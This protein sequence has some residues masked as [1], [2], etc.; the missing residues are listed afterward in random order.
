MNSEELLSRAEA[1]IRQ[2]RT[3]EVQLQFVDRQ[4]HPL[5]NVRGRVRLARHEFRLGANAFRV[6]NI[7]DP[8]LQEAYNERFAALLNYATLPFYWAGYEPQPG[9]TSE[10]RLEAM[11]AWCQAH[12]ITPKGHP[13][14][15]HEVYPQW[16]QALDDAEVLDRLQRRVRE[17]VAHFMGEIDLWDVVNEATVSHRFDNAIGR[18]IARE[19]AAKA[20]AQA[21]AWA[22]AGNP[23]AT[24]LYNDFNLSPDFERLIA[25][26]LGEGAPL[27]AIGVQSH[28]HRELWPLEKAWR[29]CETY[30]RF[31]LP[32]H[33]TEV[34]VLSGRLKAA[35]D[36]DW[37]R[38]H[39]DWPTTA[40][41]EAQQ[42]EYAAQLYTLLFSHPAVEAITWWDF[43]DLGSWQGAPSGMLRQDMTPKPLYEWLMEAFHRR[44][45]TDAPIAANAEGQ[46]LTR[47]FFGDHE[48]VGTL[49]SGDTVRG[50]FRLYRHGNCRLQVVL[51]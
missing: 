20:V 37:H 1:R 29:V 9:E 28:M 19:G 6:G 21:L 42:L 43:S 39:E 23:G 18:W 48:V 10:Q 38:R 32:L 22:Y 44:W 25:A 5:P 27:Q 47:C 51:E 33:F 16:A 12:G 14:V 36:N 15:W 8:A 41:G 7:P 4:G 50:T 46:A 24:F 3:A 30:G 13:L 26:L 45:H 34:T 35:D 49:P 40:A 31:G 17:I 11:A 2:H